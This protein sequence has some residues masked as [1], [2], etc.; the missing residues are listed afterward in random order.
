MAARLVGFSVRSRK[1][2]DLATVEKRIDDEGE[3]RPHVLGVDDMHHLKSVVRSSLV[4]RLTEEK[5][6]VGVGLGDLER[7]SF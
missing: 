2:Q 3:R 7:L 4:M 6:M 5:L 1:H